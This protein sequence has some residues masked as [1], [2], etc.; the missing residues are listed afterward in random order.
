MKTEDLLI[1]PYITP[2]ENNKQKNT[3]PQK[4]RPRWPVAAKNG[5]SDVVPP[6]VYLQNLPTF[7]R[8]V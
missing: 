7:E 3:Y 6:V 1:C 4:C 5:Y 2:I 8:I